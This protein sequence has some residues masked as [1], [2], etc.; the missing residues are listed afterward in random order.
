MSRTRDKH[1]PGTS[2]PA[3]MADLTRAVTL[4]ARQLREDLRSALPAELHSD[5]LLMPLMTSSLIH[6]GLKFYQQE[7]RRFCPRASLQTLIVQDDEEGP[8]DLNLEVS[9]RS[10]TVKLSVMR[11]I[12]SVLLRDQDRASNGLHP[13]WLTFFQQTR[14]HAVSAMNAGAG[15]EDAYRSEL[16]TTFDTARQ[17]YLQAGWSITF[18][19]DMCALNL[20]H[21][22]PGQACHDARLRL[23][24]RYPGMAIRSATGNEDVSK[25]TWWQNGQRLQPPEKLK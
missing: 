2:R 12:L 13:V 15:A 1:A 23:M 11:A 24:K 4:L 9:T 14:A 17:L 7:L 6:T 19:A 20:S 16:A 3:D 8:V 21:P 10:V 5:D 25:A 22:E 18:R